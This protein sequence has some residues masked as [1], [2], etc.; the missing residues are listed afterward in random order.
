MLRRR[1]GG[2][3]GQR[4]ERRGGRGG[5]R[6]GGI[7]YQEM[8]TSEKMVSYSQLPRSKA[9]LTMM[10]GRQHTQG[11]TWVRHTA[12]EGSSMARTCLPLLTGRERVRQDEQG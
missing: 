1:K 9:C 8:T 10:D 6:G 12:G 11:V 4:E 7:W 2:R 3:G 5:G